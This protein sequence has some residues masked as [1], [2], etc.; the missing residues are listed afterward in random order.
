VSIVS[1]GWRVREWHILS[2]NTEPSEVAKLTKRIAE[3]EEEIVRLFAANSAWKIQID[4][5]AARI[6]VIGCEAA[7][8]GKNARRFRQRVQRA[9]TKMK[10]AWRYLKARHETELLEL[11]ALWDAVEEFQERA[12]AGETYTVANVQLDVALEACR[13]GSL[14]RTM[15]VR[16]VGGKESRHRWLGSIAVT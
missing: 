2:M 9:A 5:M 1:T 8:H 6:A 7:N 10:A 4:V 3:Q 15:K 11:R 13:P 12:Y 16:R 14:V